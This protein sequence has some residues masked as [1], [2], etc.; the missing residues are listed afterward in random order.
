MLRPLVV[1]KNRSRLLQSAIDWP[2]DFAYIS[3][4]QFRCVNARGGVEEHD[5]DVKGTDTT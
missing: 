4:D 5:G 2:I 1:V 3:T